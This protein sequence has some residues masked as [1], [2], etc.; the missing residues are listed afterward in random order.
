MNRTKKGG[1]GGERGKGE[2]EGWSRR[3]IEKYTSVNIHAHK[4]HTH[5]KGEFTAL[6]FEIGSRKANNG[7]LHSI[8]AENQVPI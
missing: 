8:D 5:Y 4:T 7:H 2:M 3:G 6:T 1:K